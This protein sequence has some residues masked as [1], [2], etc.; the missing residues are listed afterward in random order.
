MK[1]ITPQD[2]GV[3]PLVS[4]ITGQVV[5]LAHTKLKRRYQ[6][7]RFQLIKATGGFGCK[8]GSL[9][10][11]V[12]G[13]FIADGEDASYRRSDFI[14]IADADLIAQALA[15]TTPVKEIDLELR[16]YLLISK[17][18]NMEA[19]HTADQAMKRLRRLT[20]SAVSVAYLL[21]PESFV[22]D[23]GYISYPSGATPVEVKIKKEGKE[24][25]ATA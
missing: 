22:N 5:V 20:R 15:D 16:H 25:I 13:R 12:F 1:L 4:D 3:T 24:W 18:G 11:A 10:S 19:G 6:L 21:H 14:G 23:L 2:K 9:G 17:D 7:P 8:E